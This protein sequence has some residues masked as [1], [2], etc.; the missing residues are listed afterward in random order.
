MKGNLPL[1]RFFQPSHI[2]LHPPRS[3]RYG[4]NRIPRDAEIALVGVP[5]GPPARPEA[6][7]SRLSRLA[8]S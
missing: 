5:V 4:A 6:A 3:P 7:R 8:L 2:R 1:A